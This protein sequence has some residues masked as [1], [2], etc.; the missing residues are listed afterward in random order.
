MGCTTSRQPQFI[1]TPSA[2]RATDGGTPPYYYTTDEPAAYAHD[3]SLARV[4]E[5]VLPH[6]ATLHCVG[7]VLRPLPSDLVQFC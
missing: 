3:S 6:T 4:R 1:A 7:G 5:S 2:S